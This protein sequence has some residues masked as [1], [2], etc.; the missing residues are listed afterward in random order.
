VNTK[1]KGDI[2]VGNAIRHYIT[3]GY[4][5]CLPIGDKRDYDL[6]IEKNGLLSK[7]QVKYAGLYSNSKTC[8]VGLR[9]TG[10]N[11]SFSYSKKYDKNSFDRLFIF[12]Q[13]GQM[14]DLPWAEVE[15][16][17]EISIETSKYVKYKIA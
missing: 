16:R 3:S 14:Y 17:N 4:E 12:T 7:V 9:I 8:K 6:I 1:S 5:V 2:A 13:K 11:Q 15:S 10:G